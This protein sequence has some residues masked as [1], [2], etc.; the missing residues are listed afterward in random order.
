MAITYNTHV[1]RV[2]EELHRIWLDVKR[3]PLLNQLFP[4]PPRIAL[5][6]NKS[7][8]GM[9]ARAKLRKE[10][11]LTYPNDTKHLDVYKHCS[12]PADFPHTFYSDAVHP[13]IIK[14]QTAP[15]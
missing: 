2:R 14:T 8:R 10:T 4:T 1:P 7:L 11:P 9:L 13:H 15:P 6:R 12:I 3:D 5:K